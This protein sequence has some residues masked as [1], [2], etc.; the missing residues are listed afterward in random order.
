MLASVAVALAQG[1][2][3]SMIVTGGAGPN[4]GGAGAGGA[5]EP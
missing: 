3:M 1:W 4:V 5:E 2:A